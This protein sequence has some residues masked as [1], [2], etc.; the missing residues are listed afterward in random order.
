MIVLSQHL[1]GRFTLRVAQR[2][3]NQLFLD[4]ACFICRVGQL[5]RAQ[6]QLVLCLPRNA[7]LLGIE[8]GGAGHLQAAV[9]IHERHHQRVF[10]LAAG[11]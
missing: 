9:G 2:D 10:D 5:L 6:G 11:R 3:R 1:A 7:L 4:T 8:L